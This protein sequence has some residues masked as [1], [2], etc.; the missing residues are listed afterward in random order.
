MHSQS[1]TIKFILDK[2]ITSFLS[3]QRRETHQYSSIVMTILKDILVSVLNDHEKLQNL[4]NS[5]IFTL[6]EHAMM[7]DDSLP[8]KKMVFEFLTDLTS[9]ATYKN[10]TE[11]RY[12]I[13]LYASCSLID[14]CFFFRNLVASNIKTLTTKH[15]SYYSSVYFQ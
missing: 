5:T 9:N 14:D 2:M 4:L 15:L 10:S 7:V 13:M 11:L 3:V 1:A 8:S 12:G 6:L